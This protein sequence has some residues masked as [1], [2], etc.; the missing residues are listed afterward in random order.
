MCSPEI[1]ILTDYPVIDSGSEFA[2]GI[3]TMAK[4]TFALM[5][6]LLFAT[7][8][9]A[10]TE[11]PNWQ[12]VT[13]HRLDSEGSSF[14]K[15][16]EYGVIKA[17]LPA[18]SV[19]NTSFIKVTNFVEFCDDRHDK[20]CFA[21]AIY[22]LRERNNDPLQF[23]VWMERTS[24]N[25]FEYRKLWEYQTETGLASGS[26]SVVDAPSASFFNPCLLAKTSDDSE[27]LHPVTTRLFCLNRS[28]YPEI[29]WEFEGDY[30]QESTDQAFCKNILIFRDI[31]DDGTNE[32]IVDSIEGYQPRWA[33]G[34]QKFR[35][36]MYRT[37]YYYDNQ[38][39]KFL[40][41]VQ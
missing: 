29:V 19:G 38:I 25:Q 30:I 7:F 13:T 37:V 39:G 28:N 41:V 3:F 6:G 36:T 18:K 2:I 8:V 35:I 4:T 27:A 10:Q 24:K 9:F 17:I 20:R 11:E 23:L 32:I 33:Q 12:D 22:T 40:A 1:R 31:D 16:A 14:P 5:F 34:D 21:A 15:E 26:L